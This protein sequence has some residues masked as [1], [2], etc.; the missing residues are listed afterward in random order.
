M[1]LD[2]VLSELR[3]TYLEAL[4]ARADLIEKL[5]TER[6]Y[7]EVETE[8]HKLKG[9]GKTYGLPEV[10][11]IGELTERLVEHGP[12]L[13]EIAVPAALNALRKVRTARD[14]GSPFDINSDPDFLFLTEHARQLQK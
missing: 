9:T 10:T 13:A 11:A 12:K 14:S 7:D 2:D 4:P 8:F 6:K 5:M 1:S 3:K